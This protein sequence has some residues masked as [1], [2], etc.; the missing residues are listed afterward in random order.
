MKPQITLITQYNLII[1]LIYIT[2]L[3]HPRVFIKLRKLPKKIRSM[4]R[5][6]HLPSKHIQQAFPRIFQCTFIMKSPLTVFL[7]TAKPSPINTTNIT[8]QFLR[9]IYLRSIVLKPHIQILENSRSPKRTHLMEK[10]L[11]VLVSVRTVHWS[12]LFDNLFV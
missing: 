1:I 11:L 7:K 9:S 4:F 6:I 12:K 3:T 2:N 8:I 5:T 10:H